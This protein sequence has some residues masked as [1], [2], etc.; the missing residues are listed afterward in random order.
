[1][2]VPGVGGRGG[3]GREGV[4]ECLEIQTNEELQSE[5]DKKKQEGL[6][7]ADPRGEVTN[8]QYL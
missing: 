4:E 3:E 2:K 5:K 8:V 1:M 6:G 7:R